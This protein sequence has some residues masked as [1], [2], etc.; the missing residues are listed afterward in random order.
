[1]AALSIDYYTRLEQGRE[2]HPSVQVLETLGTALR[3]DDNA[4]RHLYRLAG[5]IPGPAYGAT[6]RVNPE[7]LNLMDMWPNNPAVVLGKAY[8]VLAG[9]RLAY[10]LF[11]GFQ[12]GPNLILKLF[13]DPGSRTFYPD[14]Q[15]VAANTVAGFRILHGT[16]PEDPRV[17]EVLET[18]LNGSDEFTALWERHDAREKR[19][20]SKR[21]RHPEVGE[22][23]LHMH[24]FEVKA[25]PGQELIVYRAEAG[26][27]SA[28]A[29][30]LLGALA[31][32]P[33]GAADSGGARSG[34]TSS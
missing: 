8:D 14:W 6:E 7:L 27:S 24:A 16:A 29:L 9:N 19:L 3:L 12:H 30:A 28:D 4:R 10:A 23:T 32:S 13:L 26:S 11:D 15:Q 1:M 33:E 20:E 31:A 21:F 5:L 2:R 18:L 17:T 22:L 25:A 34:R